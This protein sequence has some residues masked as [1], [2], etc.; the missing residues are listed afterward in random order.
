MDFF[1]QRFLAAW[2][3]YNEDQVAYRKKCKELMI[4]RVKVTGTKLSDED[5]ER[6]IDE[7]NTDMFAK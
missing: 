2:Q 5:I 3:Q 6:R 1:P 7:G 4:R